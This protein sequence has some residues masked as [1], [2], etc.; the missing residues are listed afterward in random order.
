[1]GKTGIRRRPV[2]REVT[3]TRGRAL[4]RQREAEVQAGAAPYAC[5]AIT[6]RRQARR[7]GSRCARSSGIRAT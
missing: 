2:H 4:L 1:M 5:P 3:R 6:A 7:G